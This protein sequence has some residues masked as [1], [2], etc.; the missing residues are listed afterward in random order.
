[1]RI[2]GD[3]GAEH[4]GAETGDDEQPERHEEPS[5]KAGKF[6]TMASMQLLSAARRMVGG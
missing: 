5:T 3:D 6:S 4:E 2:D 1:M